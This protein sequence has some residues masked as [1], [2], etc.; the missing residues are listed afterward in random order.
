M[1]FR[2]KITPQDAS[3]IAGVAP[4]TLARWADKGKIQC[5][6]TLGNHRRYYHS[7]IVQMFSE[8]KEKQYGAMDV[9]RTAAKI[10]EIKDEIK[11]SFAKHVKD[12]RIATR[13]TDDKLIVEFRNLTPRKRTSSHT[14]EDLHSLVKSYGGKVGDGHY[15]E[16]PL[17]NQKSQGVNTENKSPES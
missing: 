15:F 9:G 12:G 4:R 2:E 5:Y 13:V 8:T 6:R 7:E 3:K 10:S 16:I 1:S 11:R 14:L 17:K